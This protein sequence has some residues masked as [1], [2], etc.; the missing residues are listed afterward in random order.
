MSND[1]KESL[2]VIANRN[3][4]EYEHL[5][6]ISLE[7]FIIKYKVFIDEMESNRSQI[8]KIKK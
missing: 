7:D 8:D 3:I 2:M 5:R 1:L 4:N 6:R